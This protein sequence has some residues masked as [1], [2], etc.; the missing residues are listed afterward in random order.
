MFGGSK[1][2]GLVE[3]ITLGRLGSKAQNKASRLKVSKECC[4]VIKRVTAED[5]GLYIHQHYQAGQKGQDARVFLS[6]VSSEYFYH[7]LL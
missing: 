6:V 1:E 2:R 7:N 4:L 3:L 5:A